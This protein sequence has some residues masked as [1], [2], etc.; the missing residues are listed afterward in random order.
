MWFQQIHTLITR[1]LWKFIHNTLLILLKRGV[2]IISTK[3]KIRPTDHHSFSLTILTSTLTQNSIME[4]FWIMK[5]PTTMRG[6]MLSREYA[7][8]C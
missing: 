5:G 2:S 7:K 8:Y 4:K 6:Y 3:S 1:S